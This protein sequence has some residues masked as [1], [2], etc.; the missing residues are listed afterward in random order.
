MFD[1]DRFT[2]AELY[3]LHSHLHD[4]HMAAHRRLLSPDGKTLVSV[5]SDEWQMYAALADEIWE[6]CDAVYGEITA[7]R[8]EEAHADA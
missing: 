2:L 4:D 1:L 8:A 3:A 7:R 5:F 6:T